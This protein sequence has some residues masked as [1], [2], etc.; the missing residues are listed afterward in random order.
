MLLD[1][2]SIVRGSYYLFRAST[3]IW[4]ELLTAR[5]RKVAQARAFTAAELPTHR[6]ICKVEA[7]HHA[8]WANEKLSF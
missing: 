4:W 7:V 5:S 6:S 1:L 2:I 3:C 8:R